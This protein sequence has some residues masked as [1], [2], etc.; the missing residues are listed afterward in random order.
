MIYNIINICF[1]I[2]YIKI[3]FY[4]NKTNIYGVN[5]NKNR[6]IKITS[7]LCY[8]SSTYKRIF[9]SVITIHVCVIVEIL[10]VHGLRWVTSNLYLVFSLKGGRVIILQNFSFLPPTDWIHKLVTASIAPQK[11]TYSDYNGVNVN[12]WLTGF[13]TARRWRRRR[14]QPIQLP[15]I[16]RAELQARAAPKKASAVRVWAAKPV[17]LHHMLHVLSQKR[18]AQETHD[19]AAQRQWD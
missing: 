15:E 12:R 19:F 11:F 13:R 3:I 4:R 8:D 2:I 16:M 7:N 9:T 14:R 1:F 18:C 10:F 17:L 5:R 6:C